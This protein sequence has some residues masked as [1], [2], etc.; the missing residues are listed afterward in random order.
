MKVLVAAPKA[1]N[2][3]R[4]SPPLRTSLFLWTEE[5][6]RDQACPS[7]Y[8]L[9]TSTSHGN[10]SSFLPLLLPWVRREGLMMEV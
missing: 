10:S 7:S 5:E 2:Q 3:E 6:S 8:S 9:T 4:A 1:L